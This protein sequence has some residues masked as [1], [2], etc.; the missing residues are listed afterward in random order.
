MN[1]INSTDQFRL[2]LTMFLMN[3]PTLL[4][5]LV[6]GVV[7]LTKWR[8]AS[9]GSL[10]AL[11]GFGLLFFLCFATPL[12][13]AVLRSWVFQGAMRESRMWALSAFSIILSVLHAAVYALLL[14]AIFAGRPKTNAS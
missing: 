13:Q 8:Q 7:I 2:F 3:L 6:A 1:A 14:A 11:L 5:C 12:G 9:S 10:W 4:V